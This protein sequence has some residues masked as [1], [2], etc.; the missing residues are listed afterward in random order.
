MEYNFG[1][2]F[3]EYNVPK[4]KL[5]KD[6]SLI[7]DHTALGVYT[8]NLKYII[9]DDY[10]EIQNSAGTGFN[11]PVVTDDNFGLMTPAQK[12]KLDDIRPYGEDN[13][14][15]IMQMWNGDADHDKQTVF[16]I[17]GLSAEYTKVYCNGVLVRN[18]EYIMTKNYEE[19]ILEFKIPRKFAD[20][21]AV[22]YML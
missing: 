13:C 10:A 14:D 22:E 2:E 15:Q 8:S 20:W 12:M 6:M 4:N 16:I 9:H 21:I 5:S 18:S 19:M 1:D 11:I 3:L 7:Y 17:S